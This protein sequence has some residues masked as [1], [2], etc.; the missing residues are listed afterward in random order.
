MDAIAK[1]GD[2]IATTL[3][4]VVGRLNKLEEQ[5]NNR[6]DQMRSLELWALIA[7]PAQGQAS[8]LSWLRD[9]Q[10][11]Q[12]PILPRNMRGALDTQEQAFR[13]LS[14]QQYIE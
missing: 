11:P 14:H 10:S 12:T 6:F 9:P 3:E 8:N 2:N 13:P 1:L 4:K 5:S 7:Q